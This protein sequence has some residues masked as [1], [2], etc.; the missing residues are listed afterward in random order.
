[1]I[2]FFELH[3]GQHGIKLNGVVLN[4]AYIVLGKK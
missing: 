3:V 1:M 2:L 4:D